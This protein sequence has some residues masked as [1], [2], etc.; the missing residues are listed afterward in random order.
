MKE[1]VRLLAGPV[2]LL[3][4]DLYLGWGLVERCASGKAFALAAFISYNTQTL[5]GLL[6]RN[7]YRHS[8]ITRIRLK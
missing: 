7:K 5:A 6:S 1:D 3:V 4:T 2:K 8:Y